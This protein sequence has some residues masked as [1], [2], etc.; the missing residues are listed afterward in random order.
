MK[1]GNSN[2]LLLFDLRLEIDLI[3]SVLF[4]MDRTIL[5]ML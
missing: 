3:G 2:L 4:M 1:L 5:S